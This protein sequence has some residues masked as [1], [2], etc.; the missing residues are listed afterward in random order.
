MQTKAHCDTT[1]LHYTSEF[2]KT[3]LLQ[4]RWECFL[5][6]RDIQL[7]NF[8]DKYSRVSTKTNISIPRDQQFYSQIHSLQ[9]CRLVY[10]VVVVQEYPRQHR[11]LQIQTG[12]NPNIHQQQNALYIPLYQLQSQLCIHTT[13]LLNLKCIM[14]S[15]EH[16]RACIT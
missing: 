15:K 14:L 5:L 9:K 16:K 12:N 7:G 13:I 10:N 8:L 3:L 1:T 2:K 11:W 6:M 4:S